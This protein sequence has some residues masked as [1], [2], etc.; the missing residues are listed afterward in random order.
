MS[1]YAYGPA[2]GA[3]AIVEVLYALAV[4]FVMVR[5]LVYTRDKLARAQL[6]TSISL[7]KK[8]TKRAAYDNRPRCVCRRSRGGSEM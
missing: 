3:Y 8:V 5:R 1:T 6:D 2:A 4:I 7:P